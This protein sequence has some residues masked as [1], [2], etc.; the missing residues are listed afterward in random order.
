M[1]GK[2][3]I[4][5]SVILVTAAI[6]TVQSSMLQLSYAQTRLDATAQN[7]ILTMNNDARRAVNVPPATWSNSVAADAQAWANYIVSLNLNWGICGHPQQDPNFTQC[8]PHAS[9]NQRNGQGENLAWGY[10]TPLATHVQGWIN[11]RSNCLPGCQIPA[12]GSLSNPPGSNRAFGHYTQI[13]W[14]TST[15]IGCGIAQQT[16]GTNTWDMLV[17]RYLP[18]GNYP[19]QVPY[20]QGAAAVAEEETTLTDQAVVEEED[21]AGGAADQAVVEEEV[22]GDQFIQEELVQ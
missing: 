16:I 20:G 18:S 2:L 6:L 1:N 12:D 7:T 19:G 17:C 22:Q 8:P 11:E 13:V 15:Q 3:S 14:S 5:L 10:N 21:A 9:W 4:I